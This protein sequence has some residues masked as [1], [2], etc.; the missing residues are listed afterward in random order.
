MKALETKFQGGEGTSPLGSPLD[1]P[2]FNS[3]PFKMLIKTS[4]ISAQFV[5]K[6]FSESVETGVYLKLYLKLADI[7]PC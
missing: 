2:L 5:R 3:I 6:F 1:P 4:N 7:K